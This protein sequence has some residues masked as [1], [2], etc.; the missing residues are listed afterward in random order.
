MAAEIQHYCP[1]C[2]GDREFYRAASTTLHLGE[3]VKWR[4]SEC[5]YSFVLI[6]DAVDSSAPA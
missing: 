3:K 1:Q 6:D 5:G 2:G 4:C